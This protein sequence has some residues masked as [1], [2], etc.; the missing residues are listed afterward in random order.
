MYAVGCV[1]FVRLHE[2]RVAVALC[3]GEDAVPPGLGDVRVACGAHVIEVVGAFKRVG[4]MGDAQ[5][6]GKEVES[7]AVA[8]YLGLGENIAHIVLVGRNDAVDQ[9]YHT[10]VHLDVALGDEHCLVD[11]NLKTRHLGVR[12]VGD[13]EE[14]VGHRRL[15][16]CTFLEVLRHIVAS[17]TVDHMVVDYLAHLVGRHRL[18]REPVLAEILFEGG[19]VGKEQ[20]VVAVGRQQRVGARL[21]HHIRKD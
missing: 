19:V 9:M 15:G 5:C 4:E 10:V 7:L 8:D 1:H 17:R 13:D 6:L 20:R 2:Q 21:V 3:L 11:I 18:K 12:L 16:Q 14:V